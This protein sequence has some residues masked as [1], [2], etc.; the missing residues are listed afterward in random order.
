MSYFDDPSDKVAGRDE[1]I[2]RYRGSV[3][4][5]LRTATMNE[6]MELVALIQ[7][8]VGDQD[9][10]E[11]SDPEVEVS[12]QQEKVIALARLLARC[13]MKGISCSQSK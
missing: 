10:D 5:N 7:S 13:K 3:T 2:D 9:E 4:I 12:T 6:G 11:D 1:F 8:C